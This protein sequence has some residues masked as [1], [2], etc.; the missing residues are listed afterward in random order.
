MPVIGR[1]LALLNEAPVLAAS[2][3][4]RK[5][6]TTKRDEQGNLSAEVIEADE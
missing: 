5:T 4:R 2:G 1:A 6:I 3:T